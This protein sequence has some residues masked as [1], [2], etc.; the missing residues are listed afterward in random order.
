MRNHGSRTLAIVVIAAA[1]IG[2]TNSETE[3]P[4]AKHDS[5]PAPGAAAAP[6]GKAVLGR[7]YGFQLFVHCGVLG[8]RFDGRNWDADPP[9]TDGSGNPP[10]GW[11]ENTEEGTMTLV[12]ADRAVFRSASG[13]K[14]AAFVPRR[15]GAP[16]PT[17][18]CE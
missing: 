7:A 11:D 6:P 17:A 4:R 1:C 15:P 14:I 9:L 12:A 5:A 10:P 8:T 2:C 3:A 18:N 13:D 16:D